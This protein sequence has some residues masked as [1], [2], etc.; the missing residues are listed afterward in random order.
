MLKQSEITILHDLYFSSPILM[1]DDK[2]KFIRIEFD[3]EG[4]IA[5]ANIEW[6]LLEK[7][8]VVFQRSDERNYHV[9]YQ[10]I[11]GA[12]KTLKRAIRMFHTNGR[13]INA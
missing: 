11:R 3:P 6:Y 5:G 13:N 9:F 4:N 10:L 12:D 8:R 1:T 2:G 7:S